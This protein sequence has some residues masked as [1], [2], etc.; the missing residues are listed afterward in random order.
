MR[1]LAAVQIYTTQPDTHLTHNLTT[2]TMPKTT[3]PRRKPRYNPPST[4]TPKTV[5]LLLVRPDGK[6][7]VTAC[8][9]S[10]WDDV[11]GRLLDNENI[12]SGAARVVTKETGLTL[13]QVSAELIGSVYQ[14]WSRAQVL[15]YKIQDVSGSKFQW[16]DPS[17][18]SRHGKGHVWPD[19][20]KP[21]FRLDMNLKLAGAMVYRAHRSNDEP[22]FAGRVN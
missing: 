21:S 18:L 3:K 16:R 5:C 10:T 6:I 4:A 19:G 9:N 14:R 12:A 8:Q 20:A 11:G 13:E 22:L 17:T 15:V 1:T 2:D 7:V